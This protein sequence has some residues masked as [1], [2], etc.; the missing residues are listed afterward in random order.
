MHPIHNHHR[1]EHEQRIEDEEESFVGENVS[2]PALS[3]LDQANQ[4]SH[5]DEDADRVQAV[6]VLGPGILVAFRGRIFV[7]A[8]VE[9]SGGEDEEEEEDELESETGLSGVSCH[10]SVAGE[11]S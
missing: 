8:E 10:C 6:H 7:D 9:E 1:Q 11:V 4:A 5:E 3:V 2:A